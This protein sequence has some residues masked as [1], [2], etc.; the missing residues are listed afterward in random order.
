L[1]VANVAYTKDLITFPKEFFEA[2][3]GEALQRYRLDV[4]FRCVPRAEDHPIRQF[5]ARSVKQMEELWP[6]IRKVNEQRYD[7]FFTVVP[8][9]R[10]AA[11]GKKE[12]RLPDLLILTVLWADLDVGE[13]KPYNSLD[14][15]YWAIAKTQIKPNICVESGRG[16]HPYWLLSDPTPMSYTEAETIL[17][18]IQQ[19]LKGDEEVAGPKRLMRLPGLVN[20]KYGKE[21]KPSRFL[22]LDAPLRPRDEYRKLWRVRLKYFPRLATQ[23]PDAVESDHGRYFQAFR[24]II[25]DLKMSVGSNFAHGTCPFHDDQH[26][27][28]WLNVRTGFWGCHAA[29]CTMKQ[30]GRAEDALG[31]RLLAPNNANRPMTWDDIPAFDPT[32]VKPTKWICKNFIP[33]RNI[34]LIFAA[35]GSFKSSYIL[36][37]LKSVAATGRYVLILDYENPQ[38]VLKQRD[39]DLELSL[40]NNPNMR[41]WDR[42][43]REPPPRPGDPRLETIVLDALKRTKKSPVLVFD[44]WDSLLKP[45]EG[46]ES[47]GQIAPIYDCIRRLVDLGATVIVLDHTRK[48]MNDIIYGAGAKEAKVDVIHVFILHENNVRPDQ[49]VIQVESWLKRHAPKGTTK[50]SFK[51]LTHKDEKGKW[52]V[53]GF[54]ECGDPT[55]EER[56]KNRKIIEALIKEHPNSGQEDLVKLATPSLSRNQARDILKKGVGKYWEVETT[57][58]GKL[59]YRLSD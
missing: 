18:T 2:L 58:H 32:H 28:F 6:Q 21:G 23:A 19:R 50:F 30:G 10:E 25:P 26:P 20:W 3:F 53:I 56:R 39:A 1:E 15:A 52:H 16:L 49:P 33:A 57:G 47:T 9:L 48:Y 34:S 59:V 41:I 31:P 14:D 36:W 44:S 42:F 11:E 12:H 13:D 8:R 35:R 55:I 43:K 45:G 46:G 5:F 27:S 22:M 38:D 24:K 37:I 7:V 54:E 17:K 29:S 51:P 4:E 40:A